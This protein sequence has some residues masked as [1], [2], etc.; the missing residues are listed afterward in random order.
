MGFGDNIKQKTDGTSA[1]AQE[2]IY[3]KLKGDQTIRLLDQTE[4]VFSYWRYFIPVN[5]GGMQQDRSVVV[6]RGGPI[7]RFMA[8][9]GEGDK[10]Y[11]KPGRRILF[12]VLD[13]ADSKV[14]L[15]DTGPDLLNKFSALHQRVRNNKTLKPM[16]VWDFDIQI[17][18]TEGKTPKDVQRNIFPANDTDPLALDLSALL[19]FDLR[20]IIHIMPDEMQDRLLRGEDL[21]D[22]LRE[23]NWERPIPTV[24]QQ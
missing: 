19:I 4:D 17:V 23:L 20:A 10:R 13:R 2:S 18:S 15:L 8:E 12:N 11:R 22:I 9:I 16:N 6:G 24:P 5:V 21:L 1:S 14:K 7:S 3:I